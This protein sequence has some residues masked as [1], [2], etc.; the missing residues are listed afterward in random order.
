MAYGTVVADQIQTSVSNTSLGAGN[1]TSFKNRLINGNMAIDQRFAGAATTPTTDQYTIDRWQAASGTAGTWI[2]FQQNSGNAPTTQGFTQCLKM[3]STGAN[4]PASG[5]I[6]VLQQKIEGNN[7]YDFAL[8][9]ASAKTFTFS[10]WMYVS[11]AGTYGVVFTNNNITRAYGSTY[12]LTANTWTYVTAT[13]AGDTTG[14][15]DTGTNTGM[16]VI[17]SLG[18]GSG[19]SISSGSWQTVSGNAYNV[20]GTT[21]L[22]ATNGATMYITGAQV[23]VGSFA[24]GFDYRSYGTELALC[25]RYYYKVSGNSSNQSTLMM[26]GGVETSSNFGVGGITFPSPMRAT[27]TMSFNNMGAYCAS[28]SG[29][30]PSLTTNR[31]SQ[32]IGSA[33]I[34]V[35]GSSTIGQ[36]AYLYSLNSSTYVDFTA[37]L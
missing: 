33:Y 12:T 3:L 32:N 30:T 4:T 36:A 8:G 37:E 34:T 20:T 23:E 1:A 22:S 6:Y 29:G 18:T 13:V 16:R 21:Q 11:V 5:S 35:T 15:W 24:T 31:S 17:F 9:T 14:T 19:N 27:P 25:Q 7:I 10:C 28:N 2:T 26:I